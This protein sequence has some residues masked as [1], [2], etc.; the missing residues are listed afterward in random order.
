MTHKIFDKIGEEMY[1]HVLSNG[2]KIYYIPNY[3]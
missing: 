1:S 2:L 3:E